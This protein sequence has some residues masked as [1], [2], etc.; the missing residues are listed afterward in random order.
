MI[1]CIREPFKESWHRDLL[2]VKGC[3][4]DYCMIGEIDVQVLR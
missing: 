2:W 4:T 1:A 3:I